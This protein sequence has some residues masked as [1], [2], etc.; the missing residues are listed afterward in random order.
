VCVKYIIANIITL[1][2]SL[3]YTDK[4]IK[5]E[6]LKLKAEQEQQ[7]AAKSAAPSGL[8]PGEDRTG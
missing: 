3:G 8:R 6:M 5:E 1:Y 2:R 7:Q 4:Q